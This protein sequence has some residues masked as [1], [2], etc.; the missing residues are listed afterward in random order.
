MTLPVIY[1]LEGVP[2][3]QRRFYLRLLARARMDERAR[4]EAFGWIV[5]G[6]ALEKASQRIAL[7][8]Q[9]AEESLDVLPDTVYKQSL[10][11]LAEYLKERKK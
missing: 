11:G 7:Y 9:R 8:T 5:G 6:D 3:G 4:Q 10:L 1:A 2:S